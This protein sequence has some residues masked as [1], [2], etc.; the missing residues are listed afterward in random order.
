MRAVQLEQ[1]ETG[2][3]AGHRGGDELRLDLL[4]LGDRQLAR[5]LVQ[6]GQVRDRRRRAHLPVALVERLVDALPHQLGR[7][8][9]ARV[10]ELKPDLRGRVLVH[11][12]RDPPPR[13]FVLACVQAGAARG[14]PAFGRH[15]DHLGHHQG[16][17]ARRL[18]AEVHQMKV[19]RRAVLGRV[20][21]HRRDDDA[22]LQRKLAQ[23]HRLEHRRHDLAAAEPAPLAVGGEPLRPCSR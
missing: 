20:H 2:P 15:A 12:C 1:V 11:E 22:V 13:G 16:C 9:A 4:H 8:L 5:H 23:P 19:G 17:A 3:L 10:A 6:P 21:V 7:A 18:A 14:D